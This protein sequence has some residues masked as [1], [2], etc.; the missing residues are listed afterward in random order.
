MSIENIR[1]IKEMANEPKTKKIYH[2]PKKS[3]KKIAQENIIKE[4]NKK[5]LEDKSTLV[6]KGSQELQRWFLDR[7]KELTGVCSH[8][9]GK[10]C[11][12]N[13][14]YYKFS[15]AHLLAKSLFPSVAT[16]PD[17]FLEL[18]H[19]GKS[20]HQNLDNHMIDLIDLNCFDEVIEK[21]VKIYPYIAKE[22]KRRIP[23]ILLDYVEV[24]K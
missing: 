14:Q 10:S 5:I 18:C 8:C 2:I 12:D 17:N 20:C 15:I 7:R 3:T 11:K 1:R 24:E 23:K 13:D 21:F 4:Q 16:H 6:G 9:G 19:F 22:E